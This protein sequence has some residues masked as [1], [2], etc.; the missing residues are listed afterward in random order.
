[1]PGVAESLGIDLPRPREACGTVRILGI[2]VPAEPAMVHMM[3][4]PFHEISWESE[5]LFLKDE[6]DIPFMGVLGQH[7]FLDRWVVSFNYYESYLVVEEQA[8]FEGRL[9]PE[10]LEKAKQAIASRFGIDTYEAFQTGALDSEW[11]RPGD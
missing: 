3:L 6:V 9:P 2:E 10:A 7:G 1:M 5:V 4:P 8:V 11:E